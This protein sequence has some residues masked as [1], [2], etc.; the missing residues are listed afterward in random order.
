MNIRVTSNELVGL[1]VDPPINREIGEV[2]AVSRI[3]AEVFSLRAACPRLTRIAL[4]DLATIPFSFAPSFKPRSGQS[5]SRD[6][7]THKCSD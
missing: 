6:R 1:A 4:T 5:S 7:L 3:Q 2:N